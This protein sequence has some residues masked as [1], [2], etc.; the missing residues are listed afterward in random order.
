VAGLVATA[1]LVAMSLGATPQAAWAAPVMKGSIQYAAL[2][3]GNYCAGAPECALFIARQCDPA[4]HATDFS[5]STPAADNG[6]FVSIVKIPRPLPGGSSAR[7]G[8]DPLPAGSL[9]YGFLNTNCAPT[10]GTRVTFY[11]APGPLTIPDDAGWMWVAASV[12][13]TYW[14]AFVGGT[15]HWTWG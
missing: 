8:F 7:W 5:P 2:D 3:G 11:G 6:K 9:S 15:W 1:G 12:F 10:L 13:P 4:L 14:P